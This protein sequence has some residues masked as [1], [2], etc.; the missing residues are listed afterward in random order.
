M[1][2]H[3]RDHALRPTRMHC[4][5]RDEPMRVV[6]MCTFDGSESTA[7]G[8]IVAWDWTFGLAA[9]DD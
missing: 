9:D 3:E 6:A 5:P 8:T 2:V 7:P 4:S 1:I